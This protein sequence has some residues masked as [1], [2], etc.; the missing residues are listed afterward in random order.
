MGFIILKIVLCSSLLITLYYFFLEKEKMYRFNRSF[1]IFSL[2]FSYA[3]PFISI[4]TELPE[5]KTNSKL[6][7]EET[8]QQITVLSP[9]QES[10][11]WINL[12]WIIYGAV[13][14]FFLIKAVIS[15]VRIK[16]LKGKR[17]NYLN[18]NTVITEKS[19]SPFSFWN[20]IYIGKSYLKNN[21][22]DSRIFLHEKSHLDQKHSL[23][24]IFIE[25]FKIVTWFNPAIYFYKKAMITNHEFLADESVLK[26]N[27][28]VKD[29]QKLILQEIISTQKHLFTH[30]FNFNN[31]KKRFIMMNTKKSNLTGIKKAV[32]IP[33]LVIAFGLFVQKT[34]ASNP[35]LSLDDSEKSLNELKESIS[36]LKIIQTN[37]HQIISDTI[38][39]KNKKAATKSEIKN[40]NEEKSPPPPPPPT[41]TKKVNNKNDADVPPPPPPSVSRTAG[42]TPAEYPGGANQ[43]RSNVANNFNSSIFTGKEK[44]ILKSEALISIDKNGKVTDIKTAGSSEKFNNETYRVLKQATDNIVWTPAQKDGEPTA[45]QYRLPLTMSF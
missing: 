2:I 1:L 42:L 28:N 41:E 39:K 20:T 6:I 43:L 33:V 11:N 40:K 16:K 12:I 27:S 26:T 17:V 31:T 25:V 9:N 36:P 23:D 34:Y 24:L 13:T 38:P 3:V 8:A 19:L 30:S 7:F 4:T 29:Y 32:S 35:G 37:D 22:I 21:E 44:G 45:Y 18:Y 5:P 14:L 10:F 15:I